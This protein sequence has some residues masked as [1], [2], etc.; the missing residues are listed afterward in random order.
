MQDGKFVLV[1]AKGSFNR[2]ALSIVSE[3]IFLE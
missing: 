1:S 2:S 3:I